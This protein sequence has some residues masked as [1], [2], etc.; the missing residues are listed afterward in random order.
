MGQAA[1]LR[2]DRIVLTSDNPRSEDPGAI[3]REIEAGVASVPG[4]SSRVTTIADR[5]EAIRLAL[6]E[7]QAGDT[8]VIAGKGHETTQT[9][10]GRVTPFDDRQVA[11]RA[12]ADLGFTGGSRA[13]A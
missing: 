10:A 6:A 9:A 4:A 2:A 8:V 13:G 1:A 12:L 11:A 3:L 7:A 5:A